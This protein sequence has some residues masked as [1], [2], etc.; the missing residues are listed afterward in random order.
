MGVRAAAPGNPTGPLCEEAL[1]RG[2]L[3]GV[4]GLT[5]LGPSPA[6]WAVHGVRKVE[7]DRSAST[8]DLQESPL[9]GEQAGD[10]NAGCAELPHSPCV[11]SPRAPPFPRC[12]A[13]MRWSPGRCISG[14]KHPVCVTLAFPAAPATLHHLR[15]RGDLHILFRLGSQTSPSLWV[16]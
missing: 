8:T 5:H 15:S 11:Q 12:H 14:P 6:S 10:I 3:G 2:H 7:R 9:V 1:G 4:T 16:L 13:H